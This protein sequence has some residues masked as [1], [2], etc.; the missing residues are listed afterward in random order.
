MIL[1]RTPDEFDLLSGEVTVIP[2]SRGT[3]VYC[4]LSGPGLDVLLSLEVV[5]GTQEPPDFSLKSP[6][7]RQA[8]HSHAI[9][10]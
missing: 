1:L 7:P 4:L 3:V 5:F 10:I 8:S 9:Q 2:W 6:V